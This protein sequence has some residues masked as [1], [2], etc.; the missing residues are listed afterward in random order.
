MSVAKN[1]SE[2]E[3]KKFENEE[4]HIE[5]VNDKAKSIGIFVLKFIGLLVFLYFFIV[6]L[7]LMSNG[8]RVLGGKEAS[9]FLSSPY[10]LENPVT[11]LMIGVLVTVVVQSSSTSTS[12]VVSMVGSESI[13]QQ[14]E[15]IFLLFELNSSSH[16]IR[17]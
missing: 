17:L 3:L 6:S 2:L 16:N 11:G 4:V 13:Y 7:D 1:L 14:F 10:V 15:L 9:Q 12:I 5:T 8:F